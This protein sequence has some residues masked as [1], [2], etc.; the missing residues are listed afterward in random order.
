METSTSRQTTRKPARR[1]KEASQPAGSETLHERIAKRAY[2]IY[3]RRVRQD[4]LS[5]W[6]QAEREIL[7]IK[8]ARDS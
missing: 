5:D 8:E 1:T 6:L 3:E 4:A 7:R 2:E